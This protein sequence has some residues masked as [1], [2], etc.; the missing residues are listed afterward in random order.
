MR[1]DTLPSRSRSRSRTR[2]LACL[3]GATCFWLTT[4]PS[5]IVHAQDEEELEIAPPER[6]TLKTDDGVDLDAMWYAGGVATTKDKGLQKIDGDKVVPVIILH[7]WD[8]SNREFSAIASYLQSLGHA[9]LVPDLRGHG[10]SKVM[11]R[12]RTGET[13]KERDDFTAVDLALMAKSDMIRLKRF[14]LEKN[15]AKEL[16]IELLCVIASEESSIV[17]ANW[18]LH[19]WSYPDLLDRK[20]GKDAKG[21]ILLSPVRNFNGYHW[22]T[23]MKQP[24]FSGLNPAVFTMP[25]LII[26]GNEDQKAYREAKTIYSRLETSRKR[27]HQSFKKEERREKHTLFLVER[28]TELQGWKLL[29]PR[30]NLNLHTQ[31]AGFIDYKLAKKASE[32]GFNGERKFRSSD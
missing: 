16:N 1:Q 31:I 32:Y 4:W 27:L 8:E 10:R 19:D 13:E 25:M 18:V 7:G 29:D 26:V 28:D 11:V 6:V 23:T 2:I 22:N 24:V 17:A 21:L 9:V 15:N 30:L 14:L 20:Q 12:T 3:L 5:G